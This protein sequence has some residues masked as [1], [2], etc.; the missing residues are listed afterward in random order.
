MA[1]RFAKVLFV[2]LLDSRI[3][4]RLT[5]WFS[6]IVLIQSLCTDCT[7]I[8]K[9]TNAAAYLRLTAAVDTTARASHDFDE[10]VVCFAGFHLIKKLS[11]IAESGCNCNVDIHACNIVCCF[12]DTFCTTNFLEFYILQFFACQ[13]LNCSS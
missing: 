9:V 2:E 6:R 3:L 13:C 7:Y 1:S 4:M 5:N 11:C 12:F 8:C 10:V